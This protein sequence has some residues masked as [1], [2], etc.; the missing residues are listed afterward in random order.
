MAVNDGTGMAEAAAVNDTGV[1]QLVAENHRPQGG[2]SRQDPHIGHV[3]GIEEQ[4][5]LRS[6][7]SSQGLL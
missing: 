3:A 1:I 7:K 2:Q 4:G 6:L 5:A